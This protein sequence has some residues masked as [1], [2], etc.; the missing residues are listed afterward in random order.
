MDNQ[1]IIQDNWRNDRILQIDGIVFDS[2]E[3]V[4]MNC[5]CALDTDT[6]HIKA[7]VSPLARTTLESVMEFNADP[8]TYGTR[9]AG[10]GPSP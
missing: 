1:S 9:L 3:I 4:I 6:G 7:H 10:Q 2:G 5:V 8:W